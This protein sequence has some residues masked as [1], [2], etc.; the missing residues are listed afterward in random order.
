MLTYEMMA[1]KPAA[2]KSMIGMEVKEFDA[3][4]AKFVPAHLKRL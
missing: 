4:D 2:F 1:R 3:L